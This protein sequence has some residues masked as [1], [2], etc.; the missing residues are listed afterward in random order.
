M[1]AAA[2][3]YDWKFELTALV[4]DPEDRADDE[5]HR[6]YHYTKFYADDLLD[7]HRMGVNSGHEGNFTSVRRVI[8]HEHPPFEGRIVAYAYADFQKLEKHTS[9]SLVKLKTSTHHS[10]RGIAE[11]LMIPALLDALDELGLLIETNPLW[12]VG[13]RTAVTD[14]KVVVR[15]LGVTMFT[16]QD[17][18]RIW[19][20]LTTL[21]TKAMSR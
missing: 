18:P 12:L 1:V 20:N 9:V 13:T 14:L 4:F 2:K 16:K 7:F 11:H 3:V 8:G 10:N 19:V 15:K 21:F 6:E 17:D 5:T